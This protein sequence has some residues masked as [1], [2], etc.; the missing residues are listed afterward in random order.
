MSD[1]FQHLKLAVEWEDGTGVKGEEFRTT[2]GRLFISIGKAA[3]TFVEDR[4]SKYSRDEFMDASWRRYCPKESP[5]SFPNDGSAILSTEQV[6][7][8]VSRFRE[9]FPFTKSLTDK[10]SLNNFCWILDAHPLVPNR[11]GPKSFEAIVRLPSEFGPWIATP[12]KRGDSQVFLQAK[13]ICDYLCMQTE[14][15]SLLTPLNSTKQSRNRAFAAELLAPAE[16]IR[17]NVSASR[18]SGD[19]VDDIAYEFQVSRKV[20]KHQILNHRIAEVEEA[21]WAE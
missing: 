14:Q 15:F 1:L 10:T 16:E 11:P 6:K 19:E 2:W 17:K 13:A 20:I 4:R 7:Q 5:V 3:I 8:E 21:E 12:K 18:I 9:E